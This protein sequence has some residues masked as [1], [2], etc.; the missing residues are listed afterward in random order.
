MRR[1][2]VIDLAYGEVVFGGETRADVRHLMDAIDVDNLVVGDEERSYSVAAQSSSV[3]TGSVQQAPARWV[4]AQWEWRAVLGELI[5]A[6]RA[7]GAAP[8]GTPV[9]VGYPSTWGSVRS[10]VLTRAVADLDTAVELVPR[11]ILVA[12]SHTDESVHRCAVVETTHV[13][14]YPA[15]PMRPTRPAWDVQIM[16]RTGRGWTIERSGVLEPSGDEWGAADAAAVEGLIDDGVESVFIDGEDRAEVRRAIDVVSAHAVAGRV[17]AV[18]RALLRRSAWRT[19]LPEPLAEAPAAL[20]AADAG[21]AG[22]TR[23]ARWAWPA[24]AAVAVV[25][26]LG[27]LGVGWWQQGRGVT[28]PATRSVTVD[29]TTLVVPADWR[30]AGQS[31]PSADTDPDVTQSRT[32]FADPADGGRILLIQSDLRSGST[33]ASVAT[34]MANRIRQRGDD[35]VTEFSPST[36]FAGRDVISYREAPASGAAI[37]WYVLVADGLQVS[38]GCQG[39]TGGEA[40]DDACR[41]AVAT[42]R[43]AGRK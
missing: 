18:D 20:G 12:R 41:E 25:I 40:V 33:L 15:D 31:A 32:V 29:R 6:A 11:A 37:R 3:Q 21:R 16:R 42:A 2:I 26:A 1:A 14:R 35:V 19:G 4:P 30:Q 24:A 34:S 8:A 7:V 23:R 43:I 36:R 10:G 38:I 17:V 27:A 5:A 13:P 9:I 28:E 22:R 39:G